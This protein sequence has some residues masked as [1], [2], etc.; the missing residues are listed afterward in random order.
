[1]RRPSGSRGYL[2]AAERLVPEGP[3]VGL[4]AGHR[5]RLERRTGRPLVEIAEEEGAQP[6]RFLEVGAVPLEEARAGQPPVGERHRLVDEAP[7]GEI[8]LRVDRGCPVDANG[9][10]GGR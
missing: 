9:W 1:M 7:R 3:F 4:E 10:A 6:S 2:A 5:T 8:E